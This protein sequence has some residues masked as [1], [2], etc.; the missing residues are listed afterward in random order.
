[1]LKLVGKIPPTG[2]PNADPRR[3][4]SLITQCSLPQLLNPSHLG[5]ISQAAYTTY[6]N[7]GDLRKGIV[8][9]KRR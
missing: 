7:R 5:D 8:D 6:A 4:M 3:V 9:V 1:M 2:H